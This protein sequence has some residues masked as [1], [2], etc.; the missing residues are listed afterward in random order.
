[1]TTR[2][3]TG[4]RLK[5]V[6]VD[7]S[8]TI[9]VEDYAIPGAIQ[10]IQRLKDSSLDVKFVTNTTK[11]SKNRLH[12][13]IH[14]LGF[15]IQKNEIFTSLTAARN[16]VDEQKLRP[17][18]LLED[19][20][21]EDFEGIS[22]E[23]L[24][25]VVVGLAPGCFNYEK[26]NVAFRLLMQGHPLIA[27]HK[28]RYYKRPDGLALGPGGFV[29]G[30]EFATGTTATVVGKPQEAFFLSALKTVNC[31]PCEAVMIGDD[32]TDDVEGANKI[33]MKSI[34]VKTGKYREGDD[35]K[36]DPFHSAVCSDIKSAVDLLL[37]E[38]MH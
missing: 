3:V 30:L 10:A 29:S 36:V 15:N 28:A 11:E 7:L 20:A 32:L 33:G 4:C 34:L 1:M 12:E 6:L 16:L 24:N 9:H 37:N 38:W 13:R 17:M 14:R 19:E 21:L 25:S 31:K 27:V 22:Q 8:S 18:L 35:K 26:L 23:N 5:A 2:V